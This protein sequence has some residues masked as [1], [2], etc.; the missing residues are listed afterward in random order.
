MT[1]ERFELVAGQR[2]YCLPV[3]AF[4]GL[5]ANVYVII[6]GDYVALIDTGSGLP[7][8]NADLLAA[9]EAVRTEWHED[10]AWSTLT[11]IIITHAHIDHY[12]GLPLVQQ[13]TAAP[14]AIHELDRRVLINF[15]ERFALTRR[16]LGNFLR[17]AGVDVEKHQRIVDFYSSDKELFKHSD[18]ATVLHDGDRL[19]DRFL[20]HH[21]PGHCPGQ[22]CLQLD[23]ILFSADHVLASITPHMA[24]ESIT[25]S[26]GLEHYLHALEK[27]KAVEG[28]RLTLG[29][30]NAPIADLAERVD[31]IQA[32]HR[33]KLD[34]VLNACAEPLTIEAITQRLYPNV[35]SYDVLL[36]VEEIGAHVEYLD[37][38]GYLNI[39]NLAQVMD[40]PL[41]PPRYQRIPNA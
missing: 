13:R 26:T 37:Q 31:Q 4:P 5:I 6:D 23:D 36:A 33:R 10:I 38:H 8:S 32:S 1:I 12:G 35:T 18:V 11:R 22:V 9:F 20:V 25:P 2:I 39:A 34:R 16:A 15:P 14:I 3:R 40:D 28:I 17:H 30:H 24:P 21:T 27:I 41:C 29:G 19:D 7:D